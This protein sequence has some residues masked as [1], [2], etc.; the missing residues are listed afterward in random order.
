MG[1]EN[2][3]YNPPKENENSANIGNKQPE[4][5]MEYIAVLEKCHGR[6]VKKEFLPMQLGDAYE[7]YADASVLIKDYGFKPS[8]SI[9]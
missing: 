7:T 9:E 3:L 1:A 6:E 5:L 2:I 4:K 8:T